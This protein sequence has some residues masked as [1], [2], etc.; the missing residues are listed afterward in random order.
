MIG[1]LIGV[2]VIAV[3]TASALAPM[4][5]S[6]IRGQVSWRL[7]FQVNELPFVAAAWLLADT[8]LAVWDGNVAT[9]GGLAALVVAALTLA[10]LTAIAGRGLRA[11][12]AVSDAL[13]DGLGSNWRTE[14]QPDL[15]HRLRRHL[16]WLRIVF[17]PL[18]VRR[19]DV[20]HQR[21]LAYGPAGRENLLDVYRP[22][23]GAA[24]G[25]CLVYFHGGGYRSGRK[26]REAR[27]LLYRLASQGWVCASANYRRGRG[28]RWPDQLT[29][30]HRA[31][32][33]LRE[34]APGYGADPSS[35]FVAGSSS[36]AHLAA[37][38]ALTPAA[39]AGRAGTRLAGAIC[40]YGFYGVPTWIDR[41]PTAPSAPIELVSG[42]AVPFF[43]AHGE[44]DSFV[45]V[46]DARRFAAHLRLVS[47]QPVVYA[48]LAG[49]QH[50]FD[51]Y[52]SMR[53]ES[54][55]DGIETFTTWVRSTRPPS[56]PHCAA[57]AAVP[58][59][60]LRLGA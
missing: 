42:D 37:M 27:A 23:W 13:A 55:I 34:A 16:P 10:G 8:A 50:T 21:D 18:G 2:L 45:P 6:W 43:V 22:R 14:L 26:N 19:R 48:E 46:D 54:V 7:G 49:G 11:G 9:P 52:H 1:Y 41:D 30:A 5:G 53:F 29:D 44:L 60:H 32:A 51:L 4:R 38:A 20:L 58:A 56:Y 12:R 15:A 35:V 40:L 57:T 39:G 28:R 36:G 59:S 25:P 24:S 33:W 3:P 31:I 47:R 17:I